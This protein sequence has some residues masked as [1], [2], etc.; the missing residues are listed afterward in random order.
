MAQ[1]KTLDIKS[2][3]E[4]MDPDVEPEQKAS[5]IDTLN[6]LS[7]SSCLNTTER[8]YYGNLSD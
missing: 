8:M 2:L 3:G 7:Q 6:L 4:L 5:Y 1:E